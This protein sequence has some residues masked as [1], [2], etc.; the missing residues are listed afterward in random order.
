[1]KMPTLFSCVAG[2]TGIAIFLAGC[3]SGRSSSASGLPSAPADRPLP[4][5]SDVAYARAHFHPHLRWASPDLGKTPRLLFLS[6]YASGY[7]NIYSMPDL[8]L[9]AQFGPWTDLQ[10][11]CADRKGDVYVVDAEA[12]YLEG[13]SRAGEGHYILRDGD[14]TPL[15]CAVNPI[16][17]DVAVTNNASPPGRGNIVIFP[18][19]GSGYGGPP[20]SVPHMYTYFFDGYDRR[21]NLWVDGYTKSSTSIIVSCKGARCRT[22]PISGGTIFHPGFLQYAVGQKTW[23]VA[24]RECGGTKS[25]CIYPVSA[26]GVL[27]KKITLKDAHGKPAC[28]MFQGAITEAGS[29]VFVG[30][31]DNGLY[32]NCGVNSVARWN[33]PA[34]GNST[35]GN[36]DVGQMPTGAA[37]SAK[38]GGF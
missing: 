20:I 16:N 30:G 1:M 23:Y 13:L 11:E 14:G 3:N 33:F 34:G 4:G 31:V 38:V 15:S 10:G 19:G 32:T 2:V 37:V 8:V 29:T 18:G 7:V 6:D 26:G 28:D 24:D 12:R 35:E 17:G 5:A 25:F 22:I 21:G 36:D 9:K 27:G